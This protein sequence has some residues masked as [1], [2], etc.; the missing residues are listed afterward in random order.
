MESPAL[1]WIRLAVS[2]L[3]YLVSPPLGLGD[4]VYPQSWGEVMRLTCS[5]YLR[6]LSRI[7]KSLLV[8]DT[9]GSKNETTEYAR[10]S[11]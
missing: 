5:P 6:V 9:E 2:H 3:K 7:A 10:T 11:V 8:D 4:P 1:Y